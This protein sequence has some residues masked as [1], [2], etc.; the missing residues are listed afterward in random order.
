MSIDAELDTWRRQ[1]QAGTDEPGRDGLAMEVRARVARESRLMR[2]GLIAPI[3]VT[4]VIGGGVIMHALRTGLAQDAVLAVEAWL[5]ILVIWGGCL[6]IARG[7]WRP[8]AES[9]AAFVDLSIRRCRANLRTFPFATALY[10]CQVA[11]VVLL[12]AQYLP[13]SAVLTAPP[14]LLLGGVGFPAFLLG[15]F[16][17]ARKQRAELEHLLELERQLAD[18]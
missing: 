15:G 8:F 3:L 4:A 14:T 12:K 6:W 17:Y 10:V 2:L 18:E 9:T 7:T 13:V 1:W 11:I 5:F 16:W